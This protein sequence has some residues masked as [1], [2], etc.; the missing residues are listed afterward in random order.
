MIIVSELQKAILQHLNFTIYFI[1][2][3]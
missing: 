3:L 2:Y 1:I